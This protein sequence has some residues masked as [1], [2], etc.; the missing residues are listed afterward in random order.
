MSWLMISATRK[1]ASVLSERR[2]NLPV[3]V[4][5]EPAIWEAIRER[6]PPTERGRSGGVASW[7]REL[8]YRELEL[9]PGVLSPV[10]ACGALTLRVG[11]TRAS[12][13]VGATLR[14]STSLAEKSSR[15]ADH[16]AWLRLSYGSSSRGLSCDVFNAL[17][18]EKGIK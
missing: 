6:I 1:S 10:G 12:E 2:G 9:G 4:R 11:E 18:S 15:C 17:A 5:L 3:Q 16:L 7:I 13:G 14:A 8:V